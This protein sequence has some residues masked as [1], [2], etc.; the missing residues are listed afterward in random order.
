MAAPGAMPPQK[1]GPFT[2]PSTFMNVPF[3]NNPRGSHAAILGAP[4]DCGMHPTRIGARYGPASIREQSLLVRPYQ[5]ARATYSPLEVLNVVDCGN[6]D[7][8]P[9]LI[10]PSFEG[11]ESAA[12][13]ILSAD[14]APLGFGGDGVV[15]LPLMRAANKK[16]PDLVVLHIDAHTDTYASSGNEPHERFNVATTFTRAAEE[17]V[18]DAANSFHVGPHGTVTVPDVFEHTRQCGYQLIDG[19]EL[20]QRGLDDV[21]ALLREKLNGKDVYLCFD[22]DFF[23]PSCAPGV[24]TPTWGGANA[25]EGLS[26]LQSL[27]GIDF[28]AADINTVSPPHDLG[29]MTAFLAGTVALEFLSLFCNSPSIK[30]KL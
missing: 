18:V 6:A 14:A 19:T 23:D 15:S 9:S 26:L 25:R 3:S 29:G 10:E 27:S 16:Y 17:G 11:I 13:A 20:F 5:P 30:Q 8:V 12:S 24:C 4:F 2:G 22:M 28:V 21:A 7:V 1:D